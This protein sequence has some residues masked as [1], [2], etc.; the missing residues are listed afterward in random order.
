MKDNK[1]SRQWQEALIDQPDFLKEALQNFLQKTLEE[2]FLHA[3]GAGKYERTEDRTGYRNGYYDRQLQTRVGDITLHVCRDREG[4]FRPELFAKYQ[5]NEKALISGMVEMYLTGVATRKVEGILE[6]LCGFGISKSSVSTF[7]MQLDEDLKKWRDRPL[8]EEY[9]Y[10]LFDARYEKVRE[11]GRVISKACV[12]AIGI[13]AEGKREIIGCFVANSE[14]YEAWD[15]CIAF[16]K[17]RGLKGVKYVVSDQNQGL[18]SAIAKHFQDVIWQRCQVHFMRNFIHKLSR[19][20]Q[21]E[22]IRLLKE[23][24]DA[25]SKEGAKERLGKL[26]AFLKERKKEHV[27]EWLEENIEETLNVFALPEEHRKK[28]KST[29]MLERFNQELKRRSRVIR[30]FPNENSCLR[31]LTALCQ[32]KSEEWGCKKYI[33]MEV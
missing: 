24:F 13:T 30:I 26:E 23:V 15:T 21:K 32:E 20:E 1:N 18:R 10:L 14:S 33:I 16:L 12:V 4:N 28:M 7:T 8:T 2:Q 22:G 5:R 9:L 19:S 17:T 11:D 25:L 31:L 6:T 3:M 29:N 27:W